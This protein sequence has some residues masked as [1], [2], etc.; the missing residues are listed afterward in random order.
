MPTQAVEGVPAM[1]NREDGRPVNGN[2]PVMRLFSLLELIASKDH[3]V[4][5]RDLADET[6][7]PKP[8]LHRMLGQLE[9][10]GL[11]IRQGDGRHYGTGARLRRFAEDL[12]RNATQHGARHAVLRA[13]VDEIGETCNVTALSGGEVLYLDRVETPEPLRFSLHPGSRVPVHCTA[14]G[15]VLLSQMSPGQR[16]KLLA[17]APLMRNTA[18][19]ITDLG[20]LEEE[21]ERARRDGFALD[22]EEFLPG[23]ICIA[24]LVP[25]DGGRSNTAVA[26][27]APTVRLPRHDALRVLPAL[28]RAARAMSAVE[29]EGAHTTHSN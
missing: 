21:F 20:T 22:D 14:S 12:L 29:F 9:G 3:F 10:A 16:R 18:K 17:H 4:S 13:L 8:T 2:T 24:V 19:T 23:L 5:L 26:V 6:G 28:R 15:K 11:L 27:Q 7:F 25:S 1:T